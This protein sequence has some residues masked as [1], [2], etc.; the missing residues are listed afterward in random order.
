[1]SYVLAI[2]QG[3][4]STRAII[5]DKDL[6]IVASSQQ[7]IEQS[8]HQRYDN[9]KGVFNGKMKK[10]TIMKKRKLQMETLSVVPPAAREG[11]HV[12]KV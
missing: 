8:R 9:R 2:D 4:T 11:P 7:E 5:F 12:V 3:T 1:M 10:W 6:E